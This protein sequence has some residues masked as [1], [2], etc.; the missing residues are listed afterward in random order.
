MRTLREGDRGKDV[1]VWQVLADADSDGDFGPKTLDATVNFQ[2]SHGLDGDGIVGV[3]T[4]TKGLES[5]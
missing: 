1:K 3:K 5:L 4:W 2:T